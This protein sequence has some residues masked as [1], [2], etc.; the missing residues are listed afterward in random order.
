MKNSGMTTYRNGKLYFD[1]DAW[2]IVTE[3]AKK[4]HKTPQ[5]VVIAA[6]KRSIKREKGTIQETV[7]P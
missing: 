1:A 3:Y 5:Q 2:A 7:E 4:K 6:L